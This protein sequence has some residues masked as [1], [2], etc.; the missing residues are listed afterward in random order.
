MQ[1]SVLESDY[2][3]LSTL[4]EEV[5]AG[6]LTNKAEVQVLHLATLPDRPFRPIKIDHVLASGMLALVFGVGFVYVFDF[7]A[8]CSGS[9]TSHGA[10]SHLEVN[11]QCYQ[12]I[13][14]L[15]LPVIFF[16]GAI[17]AYGV[18]RVLSAVGF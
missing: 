12:F 14:W 17:L 2:K 18:Y 1:L 8:R 10:R 3:K 9:T 16:A 4:R 6:E 13:S 11:A 15:R 5:R 7:G